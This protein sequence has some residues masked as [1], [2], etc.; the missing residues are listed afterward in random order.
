MNKRNFV[1]TTRLIIFTIALTLFS[2]SSNSVFAA[3]E[4]LTEIQGKVRTTDKDKE[5]IANVQIVARCTHNGSIN[6]QT[7]STDKSG[8]YT[9]FFT[10]D[11]C[12]IGDTVTLSASK[13][14]LLISTIV[15]ICIL[16]F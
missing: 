7:T 13:D 16:S 6:T 5:R 4:N 10:L 1:R 14:I 12:N 3:P 11:K 8:K 9:L 15:F 2:V